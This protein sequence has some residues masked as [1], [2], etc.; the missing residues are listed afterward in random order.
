MRVWDKTRTQEKVKRMEPLRLHPVNN[1][2]AL[3][4]AAALAVL[5]SHQY[6]ITG[7][8]PPAWMNVAMV[9]GVAVMAFFVISGYLVTLS[10]FYQPRLWA[11]CAK[12][13][14]T[15]RRFNRMRPSI[16]PRKR[17]QAG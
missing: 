12:R 5:F 4:L 16:A 6:P 3:R 14:L 8:T 13:A 15:D 2:D 10:W 9:G 1:F 11:F 17:H 7:T